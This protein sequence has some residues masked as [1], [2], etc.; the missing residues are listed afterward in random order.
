MSY[1]ACEKLFYTLSQCDDD[2][3]TSFQLFPALET[4][5]LH[6]QRAE[7]EMNAPTDIA[8][9][10]MLN[11]RRK[12]GKPVRELLVGRAM[13]HWWVWTAVGLEGTTVTFFD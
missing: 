3:D 12:A 8:L 7:E 4:I 11:D 10:N 5:I 13:A 2:N 9:L 1:L 6:G